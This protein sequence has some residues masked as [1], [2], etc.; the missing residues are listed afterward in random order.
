MKILYVLSVL[1]LCT[2]MLMACRASVEYEVSTTS[3]DGLRHNDTLCHD[4]HLAEIADL[5]QQVEDLQSCSQQERNYAAVLLLKMLEGH[6]YSHLSWVTDRLHEFY[7][8]LE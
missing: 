2:L 3:Y 7:P 5:Q 8:C 4:H 6:E 1:I